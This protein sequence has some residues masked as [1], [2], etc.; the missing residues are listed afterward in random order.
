MIVIFRRHVIAFAVSLVFVSIIPGKVEIRGDD[1]DTIQRAADLAEPVRLIDH[2]HPVAA[3]F[4]ADVDGDLAPDLLVGEF[5]RSAYA[6][7]GFR[8]YRNL[9]KPKHLEF[10]AGSWLQAEGRDAT[11]PA[12]C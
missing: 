2:D 7:A 8:L 10:D 11:V 3:P 5:R 9:G 1:T 6:E 4:V 12:F